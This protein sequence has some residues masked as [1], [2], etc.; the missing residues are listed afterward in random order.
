MQVLCDV[1]CI[2]LKN[3]PIDQGRLPLAR[4]GGT[5]TGGGPNHETPHPIQEKENFFSDSFA[6]KKCKKFPQLT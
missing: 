2:S 1:R 6:K 5:P 3:W 4:G